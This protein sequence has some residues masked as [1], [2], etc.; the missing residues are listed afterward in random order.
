MIM[1]VTLMKHAIIYIPGL[2]DH[3][4]P[5]RATALRLWL[6]LG[7]KTQLLPMR[8]YN[9]ESYEHKY[10]R[11][12]NAITDLTRRGYK[13]SLV[14]ESAGA[15]MAINLFARHPQLNSVVL[16]A[17]VNQ[18]TASVSPHTL[19]KAPAFGVSKLAIENS[20]ARLSSDRLQHIHTVSGLIDHVVNVRYSYVHGARHHRVIAFGHLLTITLC[21]TLYSWY[22]VHLARQ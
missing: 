21:L 10:Q 5:F 4:D 22:I 11:A 2:G 3:Y 19:R 7:V 20:L 17:G 12:S 18:A 9:N 16:I 8:W 1:R 15:S 14:G 6:L 13:V